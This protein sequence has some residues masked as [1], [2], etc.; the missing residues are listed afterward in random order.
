[1]TFVKDGNVV[2]SG[3]ALQR[4]SLTSLG[5]REDGAV[6]EA[7]LKKSDRFDVRNPLI[8]GL[9]GDARDLAQA[10]NKYEVQLGE[11]TLARQKDIVELDKER[12]LSLEIDGRV[13][14]WNVL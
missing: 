8:N 12:T 1:M 11:V 7:R 14:E 4:N 2:P 3:P 13:A 6:R 9:K 5:S 10:L